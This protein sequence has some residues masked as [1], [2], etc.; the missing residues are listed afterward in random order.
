MG[1][2]T[3]P[4]TTKPHESP[5]SLAFVV[6]LVLAVLLL[7]VKSAQASPLPGLV[8][9]P[10]KKNSK[11]RAEF[12]EEEC[13]DAEEEFKEGELSKAEA[14]AICTEAEAEADGDTAG[15]SSA[16]NGECPIHSAIA[17]ASTHHDQLKLTIGYTTTVPV[18]AAIQIHGVGSF[19]RHLGKSGV[20][21][22]TGDL[23]RETWPPRRPHQAPAGRE[24]RL[25]LG[26]ACASS[27]LRLPTWPTRRRSCSGSP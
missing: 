21:R 17:H 13:D 15:Q 19:K 26:P 8:P 6:A 9:L 14:T 24:C 2:P 4:R 5:G 1:T 7:G 10:S 18:S 3:R 25:P 16:S 12:A 20:L 22:F 23:Q 11:K 27:P